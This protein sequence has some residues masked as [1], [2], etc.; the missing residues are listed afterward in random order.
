MS[1]RTP[2]QAKPR[3]T[4]PPWKRGIPDKDH[5]FVFDQARDTWVCLHH[6]DQDSSAWVPCW[7]GCDEGYFDDY[8]EDPIEC[9]PGEIS[10][11]SECRGKGGWRV[12]P[13]CNAEN[14]DAEF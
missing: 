5:P 13:V 7:N 8:E 10:R 12:C 11:C 14:P 3:E 9:E 4:A 6:G 1:T 2:R